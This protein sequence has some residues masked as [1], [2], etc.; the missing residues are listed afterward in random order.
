[1]QLESLRYYLEVLK[2]GS[3]TK[4]AAANFISQQG[5]SKAMQHLEKEFNVALLA[6]DEFGVTVSTVPSVPS[7]AS[8]GA[9]FIGAFEEMVE[10]AKGRH[11]TIFTA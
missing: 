9:L 11:C 3:I 8:A 1:V 5:M 2:H 7:V 4:A 6:K 10:L